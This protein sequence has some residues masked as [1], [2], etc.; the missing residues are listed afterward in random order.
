VM[1]ARI[2]TQAGR[3]VSVAFGLEASKP[4]GFGTSFG[5]RGF[6]ASFGRQADGTRWKGRKSRNRAVGNEMQALLC[7][8]PGGDGESISRDQ[9]E[10]L[11]KQDLKRLK[12][13]SVE[14]H[15]VKG[16][17]DSVFEDGPNLNH[18]AFE[19][20]LNRL[21]IPIG[22]LTR[23]VREGALE[24]NTEEEHHDRNLERGEEMA[25][26]SLSK[27]AQRLEKWAESLMNKLFNDNGYRMWVSLYLA[28]NLILGGYVYMSRKGWLSSEEPKVVGACNGELVNMARAFGMLLNFNCALVLVF[29]FRAI[30]TSLQ[31]TWLTNYVPFEKAY[32]AHQLVGAITFTLSL[33]HALFHILNL[34]LWKGWSFQGTLWCGKEEDGF[35]YCSAISGIIVQM[36]F[37]IMM[38]FSLPYFRRSQRFNWFWSM[39]HLA[40][41]FYLVLLLHGRVFWKW[42]LPVVGTYLVDRLLRRRSSSFPSQVLFTQA[43]GDKVMQIQFK[44]PKGIKYLA[45]QYVFLKSP[46]VTKYEW[47]PFTLTSCPEDDYLECHIKAVGDWTEAFHEHYDPNEIV[48]GKPAFSLPSH[49]LHVEGPHGAPAQDWSQY[50]SAVL[51]SAGIGVTPFASIIKHMRIRMQQNSALQAAGLPIPQ[52]IEMKTKKVYFYWICRSRESLAWFTEIIYK[53]QREMEDKFE[54]HVYLS[55]VS[56]LG[57]VTAGMTHVGLHAYFHKHQRDAITGLPALTNYSKPNWRSVFSQLAVSFASYF[58][59][60]FVACM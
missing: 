28:T 39:H 22:N 40:L 57:D 52:A 29:M 3:R 32:D 24:C 42:F 12:L 18:T 23:L 20:L 2:L 11:L 60:V 10:A 17:V 15:I 33:A 36:V 41:I 8:V 59:H 49:V 58:F 45:G 56:A 9:Y 19:S 13:G 5:R 7:M 38:A 30:L 51:I 16:M 46:A 4:L 44:K 43:K 25:S 35:L 47:H 1:E 21:Q 48:D 37:C 14:G 34:V 50:E 53:T 55:T 31:G 27:N 26:T 54:I 6:G